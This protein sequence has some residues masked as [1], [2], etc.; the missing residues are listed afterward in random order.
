MEEN[1]ILERALDAYGVDAQ[2]VV[3]IEEMSEL[4]KELCKAFRGKEN[5]DAIAEE[6]ADVEIMLQQMILA[7]GLEAKTDE[8]WRRKLERLEQ[9]LDAAERRA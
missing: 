5:E 8:W 4:T 1:K 7:F 9:R 2:L 6:I 3:C